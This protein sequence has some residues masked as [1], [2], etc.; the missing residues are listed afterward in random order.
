MGQIA[1]YL[2][3]PVQRARIAS[4]IIEE[5]KSKV[6]NRAFFEDLVFSQ[7]GGGPPTG[8]PVSVKIRGNNIDDIRKV[9]DRMKTC[10]KSINGVTDIRDDFNEGKGEYR[11]IVNEKEALKTSLSVF[12]ISP[13]SPEMRYYRHWSLAGAFHPSL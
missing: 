10:L 9:A 13:P 5:V 12:E 2:T 6:V 7:M 1:V 11:V 3:P 8:K 4:E